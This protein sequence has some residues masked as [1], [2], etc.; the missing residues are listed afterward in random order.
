MEIQ[1]KFN[2]G[3]TG[4]ILDHGTIKE[5]R[6]KEIKTHV[7]EEGPLNGQT[8]TVIYI[9]QGYTSIYEEN[10]F[11]TKEELFNSIPVKEL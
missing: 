4:F 6:V 9:A 7:Y 10:I 5:V 3:N 2:I 1:T 11:K 8:I